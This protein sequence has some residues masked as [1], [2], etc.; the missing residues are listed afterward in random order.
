MHQN[1]FEARARPP[2]WIWEREKRGEGGRKWKGHGGERKPSHPFPFGREEI[3]RREKRT[4][5]NF[6]PRQQIIA[7]P[8]VIVRVLNL[9]INVTKGDFYLTP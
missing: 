2:N 5:G 4:E 1:A 9:C 7:T 6:V 3:R 8:L